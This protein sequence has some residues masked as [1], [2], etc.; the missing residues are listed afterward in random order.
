MIR[1]GRLGKNFDPDVARFTSSLKFDEAL[2]EHDVIGSIAHCLMLYEKKIIDKETAVKILGSLVELLKK[3]G[4]VLRLNPEIEDIHMAIEDYLFKEIGDD[5]GRLHTAR[6]RNDQVATDLR[7]WAREELNQTVYHLLGLCRS[8]LALASENASTLFPGYTHLQ[9]AQVTTLG[10]LLLA[11]CDT[12]L[13]DVTRLEEAYA[14]TNVNPL[15]AAAMAT[16][17]FPVDRKTTTKLLGFDGLIENSADAV[18]SRDF[19]HES[20]AAIAILM[21][22]LSRL[23][24]ELIMW[25]SGEFGFVELK[26]RHASTSSVMPQ[27]KNPDPLELI[28]AKTGKAI[29]NLTAALALQKGLPLTYNRDLQELS[30]LLAE[31][32]TICNSSLRI[33]GKVLE[34]L[35]INFSRTFDACKKGYLT[36]TELAE[37]LVKEENISFRKAHNIVARSVN[38]ALRGNTEITGKLVMK[39]AQKEGVKLSLRPDDI[40]EILDPTNAVE[41]KKGTGGPSSEEVERMLAS[42]MVMIKEK[43]DTL[44]KRNKAIMRARKRLCERVDRILEV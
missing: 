21:T 8:I 10:H 7:L 1:E 23:C 38:L 40:E 41:S 19:I 33:T 36:A 11:H 27:K 16:S 26:N 39:A 34:G 31:A 43:T 14:R 3:G 5:A 22:H 12:F 20:L 32:F 30:P 42:R 25:S 24:E 15:G 17:S 4:S 28:R 18:S 35:K 13:R 6:S 29:G 37:Y 44:N 2:F 9:R